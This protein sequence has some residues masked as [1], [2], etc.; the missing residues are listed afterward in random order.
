MPKKRPKR[1][2]VSAV[3]DRLPWTISLMRLTG[4][5]AFALILAAARYHSRE[6]VFFS[7]PVLIF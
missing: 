6:Q 1:K 7:L 3:I 4:G 2:A 5:A